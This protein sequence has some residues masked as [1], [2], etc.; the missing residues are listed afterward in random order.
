MKYAFV[1]NGV[2]IRVG[3]KKM[4]GMIE[5]PDD[6]YCGK[7][8][9]GNEFSD[10]K[11]VDKSAAMQIEELELSVTSRH[12][13]GVALGDQYAIDHIRDVESK[14]AALRGW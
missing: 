10:P 5:A 12:L 7:L 6:V 2:V 14:I 11:P 13:R 4:P 8:Y 1:E 9:D 3:V